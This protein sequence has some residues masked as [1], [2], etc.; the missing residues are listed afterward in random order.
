MNEKTL[1]KVAALL[2]SLFSPFYV[3]TWVLTVL[4]LFSYLKLLPGGYKLLL[5]II[6]FVFTVLL[7]RT[8][9]NIFRMIM[10]WTHH[11]LSSRENRYM[12]YVIAIASYVV[13]LTLMS[14]LNVAMFIRSIVMAAFVAQVL[15]VIINIWWKVSTHMVG[16]GGMLGAL[17]AF[18]AIFF[19]NPLWPA[20]GLILLSGAVGTSRIILRQHTLY[21]ELVGYAIGFTCMMVFI[22]ISWM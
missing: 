1:I 7:P 18:S 22:F 20:C 10:R 21:E 12:P 13:C 2:S 3:P 19:Y 9:I 14:H 17:L 5:L 11:Q 4:F 15:C 8:G 6:V 16:M